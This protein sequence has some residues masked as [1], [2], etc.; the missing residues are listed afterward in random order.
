MAQWARDNDRPGQERLERP[1]G[2][3]E[4]S[5]LHLHAKHFYRLLAGRCGYHDGDCYDSLCL[6][7]KCRR[8]KETS[9]S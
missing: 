3:V 7:M 6:V 9:M 1:A 2:G 8:L 4:P 5:V